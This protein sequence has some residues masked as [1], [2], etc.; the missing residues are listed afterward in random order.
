MPLRRQVPVHS[1]VPWR[2]W[3]RGLTALP[4][5]GH[6]DA[7]EGVRRL[8]LD[9]YGAEDVLLTDSGT[10]ALRLALASL[11]GD[12]D[13]PVL[14]PGY[15]CYDMATAAEGAGV[16]V[17]MYDIEP[18]TLGPDLQDLERLMDLEPRAIVLGHLF[19]HLV[20]V[21]AVRSAYPQLT[22]VEDSAQ[23]V[24]GRL[25]TVRLGSFGSVSIL[26]F[27]R[28]KG[29]T[30]GGGGALLA[31]DGEGANM[32]RRARSLLGGAPTPRG[33]KTMVLLAAQMVLGRPS[34]YSIPSSLPFLHLGETI[35]H[36]PSPPGRPTASSLRVL[37]GVL[38]R[39]D[40]EARHRSR[41]AE[42]L[43]GAV[44]AAPDFD[45]IVP[46]GD[47]APGYLRLPAIVRKGRREERAAEARRLGVADGYPTPLDVL[48]SIRPHLVEEPHLPGAATL[49][50]RLVTLP[51]HRLLTDRD[52]EALERWL[53][54]T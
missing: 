2:S 18:S 20:D 43:A 26:S 16:R 4:T 9:Q 13:R 11:P 39:S 12:P 3:F 30:G 36:P 48:P 25:G 42:R 52:V 44:A 54:Q 21:R 37:V 35:Y 10:S 15:T 8:L 40:D 28:G 27:G 45:A 1:P 19:G 6:K 53:L 7:E 41:T 31:T 34:L 46:R 17:A 23:G 5:S 33:A 51:T 49:A 50:E 14:I 32:V 38:H 22:V 24:G 47:E 29:V